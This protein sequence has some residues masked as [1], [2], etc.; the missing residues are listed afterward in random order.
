MAGVM[1]SESSETDSEA[2]VPY[3]SAG[4]FHA[5]EKQQLLES[6]KLAAEFASLS[7]KLFGPLPPGPA[8]SSYSSERPNSRITIPVEIK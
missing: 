5:C 8:A 3:S 4:I 7:G 6:D 2:L 1:L